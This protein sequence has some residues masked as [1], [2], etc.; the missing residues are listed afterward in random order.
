GG[1]ARE[2]CQAALDHPLSHAQQRAR[3]YPGLCHVTDLDLDYP[4]RG[5]ELP[6]PRRHATRCR[7]GPDAE[8]P[9]AGDLGQSAGGGATRRDY[10]HYVDVL[11]PHE[12]RAAQRHG[13][14]DMTP[15]ASGTIIEVRGL[16]RYFPIFGGLLQRRIADVRAVDDISFD[17]RRGETLGIVGESGCG[18]STTARLLIQ[19]LA[20][21]KGS[22]IFEGKTIGAQGGIDMRD[23]RRQVQMVF[24]DSYSSL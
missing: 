23:L 20:A 21:D 10:L 9:S 2:W 5:A 3:A 14:E 15:G 7:M 19:L 13:R 4:G 17:V 16:K 18:K 24:Q 8:Q 12:R 11:Q 22:V 1:G 6:G